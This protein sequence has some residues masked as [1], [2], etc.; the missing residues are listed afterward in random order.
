M[1]YAFSRQP[2]FNL[3][4]YYPK[5]YYYVHCITTIIMRGI[6]IVLIAATVPNK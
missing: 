1:K 2:G 3:S 6:S 5:P 4:L